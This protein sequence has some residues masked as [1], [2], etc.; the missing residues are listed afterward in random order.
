MLNVRL[1]AA[2]RPYLQHGCSSPRGRGGGFNPNL[3]QLVVTKLCSAGTRDPESQGKML[4]DLL[5]PHCGRA[6][7]LEMVLLG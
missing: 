7:V 3:T 4:N 2:F 6:V 5:L 1:A